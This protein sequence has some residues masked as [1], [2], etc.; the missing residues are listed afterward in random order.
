ML[1]KASGIFLLAAGSGVIEAA[2]GECGEKA[3]K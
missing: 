2:F 3:A 1:A